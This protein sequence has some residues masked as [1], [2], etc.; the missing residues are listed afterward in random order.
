VFCGVTNLSSGLV[1]L[2]A[3]YSSTKKA[4]ICAE[5]ACEFCSQRRK[6]VGLLEVQ[7]S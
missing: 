3:D 6:T 2:R 1:A 4:I 5:K 7:F